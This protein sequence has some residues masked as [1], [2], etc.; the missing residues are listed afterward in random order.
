MN[1]RPFRL[2]CTAWADAGALIR[3]SNQNA[4]ID[5]E[6]ILSAIPINKSVI[7]GLQL[8]MVLST[9]ASTPHRDLHV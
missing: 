9:S 8:E 6:Q 1:V 3:H 2:H 7:G 4:I 5:A